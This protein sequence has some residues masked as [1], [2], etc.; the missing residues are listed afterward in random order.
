M[1]KQA[2][3]TTK[4]GVLRGVR[5]IELVGLGPAPYCG[6]LLA[7]MGAD[8]VRIDRPGADVYL[9]HHRGKRSIA[10]DLQKEGAADVVLSL[11]R[12]ADIFI[13]GLRPGVAERL[14]VGPEDCFGVNSK[15][16]YGRMTGWG[17]TGPWSTKAGHDINYI[18]ITGAL[19]A[20][21]EDGRPPPPPINL[22]GDYGA[23]SLFLLSGLLAALWKADQTGEG[24]VIDAAIIDGANSMMGIVHSLAHIGQWNARRQANLLDGGAPFYRCYETR[25]GGY[26]AVGCLEPQF[27]AEMLQR[28]EIPTAEYGGQYDFAAWPKHHER[29]AVKFL[30][31][32]RDEWAEIFDASDACVTPVLSYE[33]AAGHPQN[34]ARESLV[35][36]A[37]VTMPGPAPRFQNAA[38]PVN[39]KVAQKSAEARSILETSG[40]DDKTI[41]DLIDKG[42]V[43][44]DDKTKT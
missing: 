39:F 44:S 4:D 32:T 26:M 17:Q 35:H 5:V 38:A 40:L 43:L 34:A 25:D 8:V 31:K 33:E 27:F 6:Q 22:V 19:L 16:V 9:S 10:V 14:G 36:D 7:D 41:Q 37:K 3:E 12:D 2:A 21:G 20:M 18:S 1:Q 30:E 11:V 15:L 24:E 13:E 23:G 28:L 29:L 42:V